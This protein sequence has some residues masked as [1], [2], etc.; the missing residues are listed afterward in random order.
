MDDKEKLI[1]LTNHL[2][3]ESYI[4]LIE[5]IRGVRI[6]FISDSTNESYKVEGCEFFDKVEG[7]AQYL[8][9][10][11]NLK[12]KITSSL[13]LDLFVVLVLYLEG[14]EEP[15]MKLLRNAMLSYPY[16]EGK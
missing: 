12:H 16:E 5:R 13:W 4:N 8:L 7:A 2:I 9:N 11:G 3:Q 1:K 14:R 10:S 15:T 6:R